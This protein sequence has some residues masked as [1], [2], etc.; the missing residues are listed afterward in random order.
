MFFNSTPS[1]YYSGLSTI[2]LVMITEERKEKQRAPIIAIHLHMHAALGIATPTTWTKYLIISCRHS[3]IHGFHFFSGA[4]RR[5]FLPYF[6]SQAVCLKS[7]P[8]Y[9][10]LNLALR[11]EFFSSCLSWNLYWA[12]PPLM[13][14]GFLVL[15]A[16]F[17]RASRS[18]AT[19]YQAVTEHCTV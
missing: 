18:I 10:Y 6:L 16:H 3:P 19:G 1:H 13:F 9:C 11:S 15:F 4:V 5:R 2:R 17:H 12:F 7:E 14:Q 8:V